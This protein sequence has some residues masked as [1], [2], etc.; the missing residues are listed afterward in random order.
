MTTIGVTGSSGFIGS[1]L[2]AAL[3]SDGHDVVRFVRRRAATSDEAEWDPVAGTIDH[4]AVDRLDGVV[5]LAGE[6]IGE[7]RWT[8]AQ[9][10]KILDSR[11]Q[12]TSTIASALAASARRR[13]G[14]PAV[15]VSGSAVGF[16][17]LRGDE[18]LTE[19]ST[20]GTGFLA[21]V[22]K[23]W[24][25]ATRPAEEGGVRVVHLRSGIVLGRSGAL[26]RMLPLFKLGVGGRLGSGRQWWSWVSL[27][28]E[29]GLVRHALDHDSI[30]GP[31]NA[32][33]P[34]PAT[35]AE[36]TRM[37]ARV[38][39]RPAVLPVPAFALRIA[40]GKALADE[41]VLGGQRVIPEVATATGYTF[42][43]ADLEGALRALVEDKTRR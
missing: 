18:I 43:H 40:L 31:M 11:V 42:E 33:S 34:N 41:M 4:D 7:K 21:D 14:K 17:G 8:R 19:A 39:H 36:I 37:L 32:V 1:A 15:L 3:Q 23:H 5:H 12:G 30:T 16:Y 20:P 25:A 26:G 38:L 28:D 2:I 24:E 29:V 27:A 6:G 9:R 35:N 10:R 22:V 13:P